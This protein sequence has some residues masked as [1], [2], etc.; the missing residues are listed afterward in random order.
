M[1]RARRQQTAPADRRGADLPGRLRALYLRWLLKLQHT[2]F[3][4][5]DR[6]LSSG[7]G[8]LAPGSVMWVGR[9]IAATPDPR[10]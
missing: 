2:E 5:T 4:A 1:A 9:E 10:I 3:M 7:C 6:S 8:Y